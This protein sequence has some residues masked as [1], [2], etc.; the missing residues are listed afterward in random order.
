MSP[1]LTFGVFLFALVSRLSHWNVLWIEEAYP[2][3]AAINILQGRLPYF[4]FWFDKP[5]LTA[6]LYTLWAGETGIPLRLAGAL[7]VTLCAV[8]MARVAKGPL[9][10]LLLAFFLTF[11]VPGAA[12][13]LGP[14]LLTVAPVLA[15]VLVRDRRPLLAGALLALGFQCNTKTLLFLPL[16]GSWRGVASFA[17][18][19][20][21]ALFLWNFE[22]VWQWG[23]L[24][25]RDTFL[26][27]PW[28]TGLAKTS[29]WLSF[30]AA[31][32][33]SAARARWD[34]IAVLWTIGGAVGIVLGLRFFPRYYFLLLPP[35]CWMAAR[36]WAAWGRWR[37]AVLALLLVP[38]IRYAPGY[39]R[40]ERSRDLAMFRDSQL[41]AE[42][43]APYRRSGDTILVWGYRPDIDTLTR[44]PGGTPYLESQPLT[45]VFADRHLQSSRPS[46]DGAPHRARL[47]ATRPVFVVD[48][49]G[50]YN[51]E[52]AITRYPDLAGWLAGYREIGRTRG[53]VIY[54]R[55]D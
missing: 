15:A 21:P 4:D 35:L 7:Y 1:R 31:L 43:I 45:G 51:P 33:V 42:L 39:W 18:I 28:A 17:A 24:Y 47:A 55:I 5:P 52:L 13:V 46:A 27:R 50:R 37:W 10:G 29:A 3:A 40:P 22:Q 8:L 48:G 9:A 25:S 54:R 38:L 30:H 12:L 41:A 19:S 11:D 2:S 36:G 23:A 14:D 6:Y 34:R 26:D 16:V 32:V 49:L 44:L 53:T 20:G